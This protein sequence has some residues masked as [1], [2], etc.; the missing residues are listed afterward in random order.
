MLPNINACLSELMC[1]YT[2]AILSDSCTSKPSR[3]QTT[4]AQAVLTGARLVVIVMGSM[5]LI[6]VILPTSIAPTASM[7]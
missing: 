6:L 3:R 4:Y 5:A 2:C 1:T 7:D